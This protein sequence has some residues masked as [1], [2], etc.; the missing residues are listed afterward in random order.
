MKVEDIKNIFENL[1]E[2]KTHTDVPNLPFTDVDTW[3]NIIIP[4]LIKAGAISKDKL[5]DGKLYYGDY[6]SSKYGRWCSEKNHF[7]VNRWKFGWREDTCNH[8]EDDDKFALFVP[9]RLAT[10]DEITE[11]SKKI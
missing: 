3:S 8:F 1:K 6:R 9:I 11:E 4:N 7:I 5:E 10:E 2:I